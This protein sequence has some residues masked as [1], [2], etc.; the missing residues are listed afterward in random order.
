M[1]R[2][3]SRA[4]AILVVALAVSAPIMTDAQNTSPRPIDKLAW[5]V[6]KTW[7]ADA[8]AA[9]G[10]MQRIETTYEWA[11]NK[12][13]I[14]FATT[15]VAASGSLI[16]YSGNI[17]ADQ[18]GTYAMWYMDAKGTIIQGPITVEGGGDW[19]S[20]FTDSDST[21][22]RVNIARATENQYKWTLATQSGRTWTPML[23]LTFSRY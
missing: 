9:G 22:Y 8:T 6:G 19:S 2:N 18:S 12:A 23:A 21:V 17:Y 10:G 7:V 13:F 11:P 1:L 14:R 16:N 5:M 3:L 15:F 4:I 20:Q